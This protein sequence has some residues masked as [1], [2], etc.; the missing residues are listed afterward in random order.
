[1]S[2]RLRRNAKTLDYLSSCDKNVGKSI[3]S[4]S[5]SDLICCFSEICHNLLKG[6]IPLSQ[7]EKS[8]LSKY[9]SQIR[10]VAGKKA[11]IKSK[12]QLIQKGGFLTTL[13]GSLVSSLLGPLVKGI[14]GKK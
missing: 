14:F 4:S 8:K 7:S 10:S 12:K 3:I 6:N 11:S 9:K 1:M 5:K 2:K 13:L